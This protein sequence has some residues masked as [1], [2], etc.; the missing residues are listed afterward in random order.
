MNGDR[1][2]Q[3]R[4]ALPLVRKIARR[5]AR[6]VPAAEMDDLIGDGCVG[7]I[8]A[9]DA[10]DPAR[11]TPLTRYAARVITG[12]MLNGMRRLDPVSERVRRELREAERERFAL[13]QAAGVLP[14]PSEMEHRRPALHRAKAHAYRYKPLSLDAPLPMGE[15]LRVDW[16]GD[17]GRAAM[18]RF[19]RQAMTAALQRLSTRQ[20]DVVTRFYFRGESLR[21]IGRAMGISAQRVSQLHGAAIRNMRKVM[22]DGFAG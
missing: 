12:S 11:G 22:S 4:A 13:A 5:I 17:P 9:V 16:S 10:F 1:E 20:R 14:T 7:L 18:A 21:G 15:S 19:D 2:A 8:R 3:I 6:F